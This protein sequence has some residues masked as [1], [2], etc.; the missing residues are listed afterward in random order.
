MTAAPAADR[1]PLLVL[2]DSDAAVSDALR[3]QLELEGYEVETFRDGGSVLASWV[4]QRPGCHVI[5]F[6]LPDM[7]GLAL[8]QRLRERGVIMPSVLIAG[9]PTQ[10]VRALARALSVPIVEKPLMKNELIEAVALAARAVS[11]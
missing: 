10:R 2:I 5:D 9:Q 3:F 8:L 4:G 7:D 1:S 11:A 6:D